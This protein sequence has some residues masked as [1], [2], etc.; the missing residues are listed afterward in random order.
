M[1]IRDS[2]TAEAGLIG[3]E[4]APGSGLRLAPGVLVEV[5]DL[6]TGAPLTEGEGE[7]VVTLLRPDY[8]LAVSYTHL[9]VYKRQVGVFGIG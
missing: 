1:C 4:T 8:P 2:G 6:T 3:Y 5:C 9:D 7:V